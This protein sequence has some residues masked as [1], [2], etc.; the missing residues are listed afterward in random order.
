[1]AEAAARVR[2]MLLITTLLWGVN[3]TAIK[4]LTGLFDPVLLSGVRMLAALLPMLVLLRL[5]R[6]WQTPSRA[7]WRQL[8]ACGVLMVYLNQWWLA[9]GLARSSATHGALI[10]ALNPLLSAMLALWLLREALSGR[11]LCGVG[12]GLAGVALVI[13]NRPGAELVQGGLGDGL[14]VL[15]VLVFT[16]GAVLI[17][18]L[19]ADLNAVVIGVGVH[20]VGAACL[21]VHAVVQGAWNGWPTM[22]APGSG[23]WAIAVLSGALS[24]GLG[25]LMWNRAIGLV[26]MARAAVWLYWVPLFGVASA[27]VLLGEPLTVWHALGLG[28]VFIGTHLGT[29]VARVPRATG[30]V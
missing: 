28:L 30:P 10:T 3:L 20:A 8:A 15:A 26:G 11:R 25:N 27:V 19:A 2:A 17:Q 1:M 21:L 13:L 23:W 5:R 4:W 16:L 18:R 24:T 6:C 9:E 14:V 7:Q 12:L 22:P 29:H